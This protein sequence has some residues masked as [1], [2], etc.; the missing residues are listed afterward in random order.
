MWRA[1]LSADTARLGHRARR[2]TCA[3]SGVWLCRRR[4]PHER[5]CLWPST[6]AQWSLSLVRPVLRHSSQL[7]AEGARM[8]W[9][10]LQCGW[11]WVAAWDWSVTL[12]LGRDLWKRWGYARHWY[13]GHI[14]TLGFGF[15]E[16]IIAWWPA[17][18]RRRK[19]RGK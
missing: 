15:G 19:V 4:Q 16:V 17:V 9:P 10:K 12:Y 11:C 5:L 1:A 2:L 6:S 8:R 7:A 14:Y 13:D 3:R 18:T